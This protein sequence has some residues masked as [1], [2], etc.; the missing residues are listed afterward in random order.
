M[1]HAAVIFADLAGFTALTEAHGDMAAADTAEHLVA[2]ARSV[3][4]VGDRLIKSI[5]DAVLLNSSTPAAAVRLIV[6]L[7]QACRGDALLPDLRAGAHYGPIVAR[8]GD[9][10]GATV[11]IA[12]RVAAHAGGGQILVTRPIAA[13]VDTNLRIREHGIVSLRNVTTPI[14]VFE[15]VDTDAPI[16][17]IDPVCRMPVD[18][19]HAPARLSHGTGDY[20]FCSLGCAARFAAHPDQYVTNPM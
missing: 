4:D 9:I 20:L 14:E 8:D 19:L 18:P 11:N 6:A 17:V 7:V 10:F 15:L 13:A 1:E 16:R 2:A 3:L 12:A 5:G